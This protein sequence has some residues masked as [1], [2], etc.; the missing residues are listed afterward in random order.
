M[1]LW[2]M[3]RGCHAWSHPQ[4]PGDVA[5]RHCFLE[6]AVSL[7]GCHRT[8][9]ADVTPVCGVIPTRVITVLAFSKIKSSPLSFFSEVY[10]HKEVGF[11]CF[12]FFYQKPRA[13]SKCSNEISFSEL[14][15]SA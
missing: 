10:I 11:V 6:G 3:G 13:F 15:K 12:L 14:N 5:G 9:G 4:S 1:N 2:W 8:I 7:P